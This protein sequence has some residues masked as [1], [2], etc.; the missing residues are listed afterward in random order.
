MVD[1]HLSPVAM[2][3]LNNYYFSMTL[4]LFIV[5]IGVCIKCSWYIRIPLLFVGVILFVIGFAIKMTVKI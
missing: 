5:V 2:F 1:L 4:G 3:M